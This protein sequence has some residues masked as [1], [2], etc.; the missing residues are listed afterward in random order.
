MRI[1][2]WI[3]FLL[4]ILACKSPETKKQ[5]AENDLDA[6]RL[7]IRAALDGRF[8]L[9]RDYLLTDSLNNNYIDLAERSYQ[10]LSQADKESYKG[11]TIVV[12]NNTALSDSV[13]VLIYSN[14]FKNDQ[15]TLRVIRKDGKWLVDLKY[16]FGHGRNPENPTA[17]ASTDTIP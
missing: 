11:S 13:T 3:L 10:R 9:A 2:R 14:S 1:N 16:L 17:A 4:L 6:G 15:D 8:D 7:F 12:H 5:A